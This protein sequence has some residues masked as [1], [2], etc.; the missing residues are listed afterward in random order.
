[1]KDGSTLTIPEIARTAPFPVSERTI[2]RAILDGRLP[3]ALFLGKYRVP[4]ADVAKF[5]SG[6]APKRGRRKAA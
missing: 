5:F 3:A 6:A 2:R 4:A 1:M